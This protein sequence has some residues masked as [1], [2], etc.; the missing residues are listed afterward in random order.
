MSMARCGRGM[1]FVALCVILSVTLTGCDIDT[2]KI[3][4]FIN[5]I[6]DVIAKVAEAKRRVTPPKRVSRYS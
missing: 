2:Q 3:G 1:F 4:N 6:A 5:K